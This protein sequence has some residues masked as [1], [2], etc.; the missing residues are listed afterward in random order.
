[1]YEEPGDGATRLVMDPWS[2]GYTYE[3]DS[4][5]GTASMIW[6]IALKISSYFVRLAGNIILDVADL[7]GDY[8]D[9]SKGAKSKLLHS[10]YYPD[11]VI[12]VWTQWDRWEVYYTSRN[13]EWYRHHFASYVNSSGVTRTATRDYTPD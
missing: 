1:M 13:R 2:S 5:S 3:D 11:K 9:K 12:E 6:N 8:V 7:F 4:A 10:Y